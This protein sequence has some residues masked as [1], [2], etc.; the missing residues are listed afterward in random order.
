MINTMILRDVMESCLPM[1]YFDFYFFMILYTNRGN[2]FKTCK[3][4]SRFSDYEAKRR[5]LTEAISLQYTVKGVLKLRS[6]ARWEKENTPT[7]IHTHTGARTHTHKHTD[8]QG[9]P[10]N[11]T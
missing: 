3:L 7:L 4:T 1:I 8:I 9:D 5:K 6:T 2:T 10:T 11:L